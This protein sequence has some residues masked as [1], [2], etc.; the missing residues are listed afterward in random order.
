MT[1]LRVHSGFWLVVL[2]ARLSFAACGDEPGDQAAVAAAQAAVETACPCAPA[3][4]PSAYVSCA[5]S[6]LAAESGLRAECRQAL[7]RCA[8]RSVCGRP[9]AVTCCRT[10]ASGAT[11]CAI[12]GDASRCT[13]PLGGSACVGVRNSCCDAC[14]T[15]GCA[16]PPTTTTSTVPLTCGNGPYPACGGTCSPGDTCLAS[17]FGGF[18]DCFPDGSQPCGNSEWPV[19]NGQCPTGE[20]CGVLGPR[21]GCGCVPEGTTACGETMTC[22]SGTCPAGQ[23]CYP[24]QFTSMQFP[25]CGCAPTDVPCCSGGLACGAGQ[26]CGI[27]PMICFCFP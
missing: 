23:S 25:G 3:A 11:R 2:A 22:G 7:A 10:R 19:C 20:R 13:A 26:T 18:C 6:T 9:G 24:V 1:L 16:P 21:G 15:G 27:G 17:P 14:V 12:K 8:A 4:S 5:R